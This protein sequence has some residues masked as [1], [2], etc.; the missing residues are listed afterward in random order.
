MKYALILFLLGFT[1]CSTAQS[2][3]AEL[4][5]LVYE[6]N[7]EMDLPSEQVNQLFSGEAKELINK[8]HLVYRGDSVVYV[9]FAKESI[10]RALNEIDNLKERQLDVFKYVELNPKFHLLISYLI[11]KKLPLYQV[12]QSPNP[13]IFTSII[14]YDCELLKQFGSIAEEPRG[15]AAISLPLHPKEQSLSTKCLG[16]A[17][18]ECPDTINVGTTFSYSVTIPVD[19]RFQETVLPPFDKA[20]V[21]VCIGPL[22][23]TSI[24]I[25]TVNGKPEKTCS[26]TYKYIIMGEAD[27][28]ITIPSYTIKSRSN[29]NY[30]S[31]PERT[32]V[33][34]KKYKQK[35]RTKDANSSIQLLGIHTDSLFVYTT[36]DRTDISINDSVLV[37]TRLYTTSGYRPTFL[38][39]NQR[40]LPDFCFCQPIKQDSISMVRDT[41]NGIKYNSCVID[42]YWLHPCKT[43][44]I[45]IPSNTY[46]VDLMFRDES[47]DPFEAFFNGGGW[48]Y[49][50]KENRKTN[51]V[52]IKVK[53]SPTFTQMFLPEH[54]AERSGVVYALD[55]SGSMSSIADFDGT[56]LKMAKDVIRKSCRDEVTITPFAVNNEPSIVFP[57]MSHVLDTIT[58]PK[59]GDGTALYDLCMSMVMDYT[60]TCR[61]IVIFTDGLDNCSHISLKTITEIMQQNGIRVNVVSINSERDSVLFTYPVLDSAL[62][63]E[64]KQPLKSELLFLTNETGGEW[65][66][67]KNRNE[68]GKV[69]KRIAAIPYRPYKRKKASP[70]TEW[71]YD[72]LRL[73]YLMR[74]Y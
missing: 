52:S 60:N 8:N 36:V 54:K 28:Y 2:I 74:V 42:S 59:T 39:S 29:G 72:R 61:D 21:T 4:K 33:C 57:K 38:Q 3:D 46:T 15:N 69:V 7:L 66:K 10:V 49:N 19:V 47:I 41:L 17:K 27:K 5:R 16:E 13:N 35:N 6:A 9:C 1:L 71:L 12:F 44:T 50:I 70:S 30:Y 24:N 22:L 34:T 51:H 32:I 23:S 20:N 40:T 62:I 73:H 53:A 25:S 68:I 67:C 58:Q 14:E 43:G 55:I 65:V 18:V 64:N 45:E 26:K 37:T 31:V 63:V 48:T 11:E 56:R